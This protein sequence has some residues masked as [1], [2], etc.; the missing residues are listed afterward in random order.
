MPKIMLVTEY[1]SQAGRKNFKGSF[2]L[3]VN[4]QSW[5]CLIYCMYC[6]RHKGG[7]RPFQPFHGPRLFVT[8]EIAFITR[9]SPKKRIISGFGW[10]WAVDFTTRFAFT[11]ILRLEHGHASSST[12]TRS[13]ADEIV[14]LPTM[15]RYF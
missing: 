9:E 6:A 1:T 4:Y 5:R 2:T 14:N 7:A 10:S 15:F 8:S 13:T 11:R 3:P 12:V